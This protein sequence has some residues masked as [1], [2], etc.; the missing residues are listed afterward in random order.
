M[1]NTTSGI[2]RL[3]FK[4]P[5]RLALALNFARNG[6]GSGP[7]EFSVRLLQWHFEYSYAPFGFVDL[8]PGVS[9]VR[10]PSTQIPDPK[11]RVPS[12]KCQVPGHGQRTTDNGRAVEPSTDT[13][14]CSLTLSELFSFALLSCPKAAADKMR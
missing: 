3:F 1:F 4:T 12:A 11:K 2:H 8:P 10:D 9:A 13:L 7:C 14:K 6:P 5:L